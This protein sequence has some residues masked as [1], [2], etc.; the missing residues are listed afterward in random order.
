MMASG[1]GQ[2]YS[3]SSY[4]LDSLIAPLLEL[5]KRGK[6][7]TILICFKRGMSVASLEITWLDSTASPMNS[8]NRCMHCT[9]T[10]LSI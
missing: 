4:V 9:T 10:L 1:G 8:V 6:H 2:V 7:A 3:L 5:F